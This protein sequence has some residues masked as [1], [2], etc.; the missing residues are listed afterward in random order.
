MRIYRLVS[1]NVPLLP[2]ESYRT[3]P[4]SCDDHLWSQSFGFLKEIK[5][6]NHLLPFVQVIGLSDFYIST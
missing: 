3:N 4:N 5:L 2:G 1:L 6:Y